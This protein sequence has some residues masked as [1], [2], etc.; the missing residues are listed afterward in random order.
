[1]SLKLLPHGA[2]GAAAAGMLSVD[3]RCKTLDARAN[4]YA[5]S[6]AVGALVLTQS[7]AS[8]LLLCGRAVRQITRA[9]APPSMATV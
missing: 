2:L 6:E 5:K 3:G 4:G 8:G 9:P 1:M 7:G